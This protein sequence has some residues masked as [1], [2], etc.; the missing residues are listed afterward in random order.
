[1]RPDLDSTA[2]IRLWV[3]QQIDLRIQQ[4]EFEDTETMSIEEARA[5]VHAAI[6]EEYAKL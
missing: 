3:Q 2:A 6:H 4:M 5:M 1:M